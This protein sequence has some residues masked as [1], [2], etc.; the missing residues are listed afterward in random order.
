MELAKLSW[1]SWLNSL[2]KLFR[3][4]D[5]W[6]LLFAVLLLSTGVLTIF[7]TRPEGIE[8]KAQLGTGL[9]G[10]AWA[11]FL[12]R[13]TYGWL[14]R[15]SWLIYSSACAMLL[16]VLFTGNSVKGAQRWIEFGG[17]QLQPSEF[18]KLGVIIALA[19]LIQRYP[20]RSF[21]QIW[22]VLGVLAVP[23]LLVFKQPDLGTALVFGAISLGM[24]YWGGARLGW[25][26]LV[27]SP[28][29]AA[30]LYAIW[31]PAWIVWVAAMAVVA[32]RE[33][34]WR[35]WGA[36]GAGAINLVAGGLGQVFWHLLKPYQQQRLVVFLD[37]SGDPLGSG[38]HILQS[39]IAIGAGGLWGRG[40]FQGTQTQLNFIPEQHTDFIFSALGEEWGFLGAVVLLGL[41]F[42]LFARLLLIAQNSADDFGSLLTIGV[43]TML[44]FQT[45]VNI[46][47]TI[48]LAPVTGIPLPFV[49]FGRSFLITCFTAIGLVES[50]ALHRTK[51][52]FPN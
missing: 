34:D 38:Y 16:G 20:I 7:S 39:E 8:W 23:F 14:Q 12:S 32:W 30:I 24:L 33:L 1:N 21:G 37:P 35:W 51:M 18:A 9:V 3:G 13:L 42:C 44:L 47:M 40:I 50:V 11:L 36:I 43:F 49:T 2:Y 19:A 25:L 10:I 27:V 48:G 4:F 15:W 45:V 29:M 17:I 52:V 41:F 28:L 22:V 6:L 31:I 5:G 46:G 26:A